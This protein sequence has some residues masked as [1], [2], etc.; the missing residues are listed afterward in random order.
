MGHERPIC[1]VRAMSAYPSTPDVML[2]AAKRR[3]GPNPDKTAFNDLAGS[4]NASTIASGIN[5]EVRAHGNS[6]WR[7]FLR[8]REGRSLWRAGRHG[9]LPLSIM[10]FVVWGT[11]E[12]F[13][14][15]GNLMRSESLTVQNVALGPPPLFLTS[16]IPEKQAH[17]S[18]RFEVGFK[19]AT[20]NCLAV[21]AT[22][23]RGE[24]FS[25]P[26]PARRRTLTATLRSFHR[27]VPAT[28]D[29]IAQAIPCNPCRPFKEGPMSEQPSD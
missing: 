22:W 19:F 24:P 6:L 13:S 1:D 7:M 4:G 20:R 26:H 28:D 23:N 29:K 18:E 8:C 21:G 16:R 25:Y 10:P 17:R 3:S 27:V 5:Q 2:S 12:C 11:G 9:L 15:Y 14:H